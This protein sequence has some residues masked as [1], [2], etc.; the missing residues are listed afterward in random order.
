MDITLP[1]GDKFRETRFLYYFRHRTKMK[2]FGPYGDEHEAATAFQQVYGY[3]P[4][5]AEAVTPY[6]KA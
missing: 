4:G 5:E 2:E 1:T 6:A 3:W